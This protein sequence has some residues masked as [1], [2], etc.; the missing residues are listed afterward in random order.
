MQDLATGTDACSMRDHLIAAN[1]E[2]VQALQAIE[3]FESLLKIAGDRLD[4]SRQRW[5]IEGQ[6]AVLDAASQT[7]ATTSSQLHQRTRAFDD[8][9]TRPPEPPP[10]RASSAR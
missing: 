3:G 9:L 6:Y 10:R 7:L 2:M 5:L 4:E 1:N 8:A